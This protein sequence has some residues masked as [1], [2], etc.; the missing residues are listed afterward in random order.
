MGTVSFVTKTDHLF[1]PLFLCLKIT[2]FHSHCVHTKLYFWHCI[3]LGHFGLCVCSCVVLNY[4]F[5]AC[6]RCLWEI[7]FGFCFGAQ[8]G[9]WKNVAL[10]SAGKMMWGMVISLT[11]WPCLWVHSSNVQGFWTLAVFGIW[12]ET[13][14]VLDSR[15][16]WIFCLPV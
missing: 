11:M 4:C 5:R 6:T 12:K 9:S 3:A 8:H 2:H 14:P 15:E 13:P 10:N 7:F 1:N 16:L